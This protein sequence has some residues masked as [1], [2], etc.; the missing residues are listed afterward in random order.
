MITPSGNLDEM[1]KGRYKESPRNL[2]SPPAKRASACIPGKVSGRSGAGDLVAKED[3][4]IFA[5]G[6]VYS[7]ENNFDLT[8]E[9]TQEFLRGGMEAE[10]G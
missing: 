2:A 1:K 4:D 5:P 6:I 9:A 7:Y 10:G 8:I 3:L